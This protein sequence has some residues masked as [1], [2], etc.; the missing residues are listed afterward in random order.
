MLHILDKIN[1]IPFLTCHEFCPG[2]LHHSSSHPLSGALWGVQDLIKKVTGTQQGRFSVDKEQQDQY[3]EHFKRR[4][5][6]T[7]NKEA[8]GSGICK[9][10]GA[11]GNVNEVDFIKLKAYL[12]RKKYYDEDAEFTDPGLPSDSGVQSHSGSQ[13]LPSRGQP[14]SGRQNSTRR[15]P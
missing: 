5:G 10:E 11:N 14:P 13:P 8:T 15:Q 4:A 2:A 1:F 6:K 9:S 7:F 12:N 3:V